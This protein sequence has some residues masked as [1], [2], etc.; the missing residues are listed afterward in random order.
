MNNSGNLRKL[1]NLGKDNS[2]STENK[3]LKKR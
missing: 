2:L 1:K 3:K